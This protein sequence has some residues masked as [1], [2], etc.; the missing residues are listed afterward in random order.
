MR[1]SLFVLWLLTA[2]AGHAQDFNDSLARSRNTITQ[3][4]MIALGSFAIV[5]IASGFIVAGQTHGVAHYA[6]SMNG[7]WNLVNLGIASMG[8]LGAT[9]ALHRTWTLAQNERAQLSVE[10]TYVL[11]FGLDLVYITGG[12]Y[13]NE[14]GN[15]ESNLTSRDQYRGYGTSI[16]IQGGFLLLLDAAMIALHHHNSIRI[17]HKLQGLSL[18]A[19]P[20]GMS[21]CYSF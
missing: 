9:R 2:L 3:D 17:N 20:F 19:A 7:Y 16:S 13:L 5:N 8:Y 6:W 15:S 12:F 18:R 14:R 11:N 21:L 10:K 1:K 4:A